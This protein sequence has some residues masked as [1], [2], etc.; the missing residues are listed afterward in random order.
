MKKKM[1]EID[2]GKLKELV[3]RRGWTLSGA[4]EQMG[5]NETY[6]NGVIREGKISIPSSLLIDRML[7]I[8]LEEYEQK[9]PEQL[10]FDL[11]DETGEKAVFP[12][13]LEELEE[14][15]FRATERALRGF[16]YRQE[17]RELERR[18]RRFDIEEGGDE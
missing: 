18:S 11:G 6:L 4:S 1:I 12:F 13:T 2:G 5:M 9:G 16:E 15:I 8:P 3:G 7:N 14:A 10:E 17:Q